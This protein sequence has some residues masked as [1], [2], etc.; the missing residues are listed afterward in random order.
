MPDEARMLT[1]QQATAFYNR[2]GAKRDWQAF[3]KAPAMRDPIAHASFETTQCHRCTSK[4]YEPVPQGIPQRLLR[5]SGRPFWF[6]RIE[7]ALR[8]T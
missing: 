8:V 2:L 5:V 7:V 4:S 1:H 3:Y 6:S